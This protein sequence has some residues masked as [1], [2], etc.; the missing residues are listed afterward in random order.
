[1]GRE[2]DLSS[3]KYVAELQ[4]TQTIWKSGTIK[5]STRLVTNIHGP[6]REENMEGEAEND[7]GWSDAE[8]VVMTGDYT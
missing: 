5:E 7:L 2:C 4:F 3:C 1:M 8:G 6:R